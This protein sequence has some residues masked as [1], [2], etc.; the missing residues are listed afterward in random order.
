MPQVSP[1]LKPVTDPAI[2]AQLNAPNEP[3]QF[4]A[5][6]TLRDGRVI[7]MPAGLTADQVSSIADAAGKAGPRLTPVTD[8]AILAQLNAPDPN[9]PMQEKTNVEHPSSP[10]RTA[11]LTA[12]AVGR[13]VGADMLGM[14]GDA[15]EANDYFGTKAVNLASDSVNNG[16]IASI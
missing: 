3:N 6:L 8:P 9:F 16:D 10:A 12:R 11:G 1:H 4:P 7:R 5:K 15:R 13:G 14:F 2:L